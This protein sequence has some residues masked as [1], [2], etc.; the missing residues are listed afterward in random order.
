MQVFQIGNSM[1][2]S[3]NVPAGD[4]HL[5][6]PYLLKPVPLQKVTGLRG[7]RFTGCEVHLEDT[8]GLE[9][10]KGFEGQEVLGKVNTQ[11]N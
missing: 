6:K 9:V 7:Y 3:L 4:K 8:H 11:I 10:R 2:S 1:T 5:W